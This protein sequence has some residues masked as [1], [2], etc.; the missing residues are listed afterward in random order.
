M[1]TVTESE[2]KEIPVHFKEV[3]TSMIHNRETPLSLG[4][5]SH[6][7]KVFGVG[8]NTPVVRDSIGWILKN[9]P[10]YIEV[11]IPE[12]DKLAEKYRIKVA[13]S[14]DAIIGDLKLKVGIPVKDTPIERSKA[15]ALKIIRHMAETGEA[16]TAN[17]MAEFV[18]EKPDVG[19]ALKN[20]MISKEGIKYFQI[21]R[22][23]VADRYKWNQDNEISPEEVLH[24]LYPMR[25]RG[26]KEEEKE[27]R[28]VFSNDEILSII[29]N[30]P[31]TLKQLCE[32]LG[33]NKGSVEGKLYRLKQDGIK[34][35]VG[36]DATGTRTFEYKSKI[37]T[38][39]EKDNHLN[40]IGN[41]ERK[42]DKSLDV[43]DR[44][45]RALLFNITKEINCVNAIRKPSKSV[46]EFDRNYDGPE[47]ES[48]SQARKE[49]LDDEINT[50]LASGHISS[51][52]PVGG[53]AT[54]EYNAGTI[55]INFSERGRH[56]ITI[57]WN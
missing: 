39:I 7:A 31:L 57:K 16:M 23:Q 28:K 30:K 34:I 4:E 48:W 26:K 45:F 8:I 9:A 51:E 53:V 17:Q 25:E 47:V 21:L 22:D 49:W 43:A 52:I 13:G 37:K 11:I 3:V 46:F 50:V 54:G 24:I 14:P 19:Y 27:P 10:E 40:G 12:N 29:R 38:E 1:E 6:H 56:N 2:V 20:K 42:F 32:K 33:R 35:E 41:T 36:Q 44:L 18:G 15:R 55:H 5:I